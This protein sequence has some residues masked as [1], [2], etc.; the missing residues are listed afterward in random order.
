MQGLALIGPT[1]HFWYGSLGTIVK[2]SGNTGAILRL[3]LDQLCFAPVFIGSECKRSCWGKQ[4]RWQGVQ[5]VFAFQQ[6]T[7][8]WPGQRPRQVHGGAG[9]LLRPACLLSPCPCCPAALPLCPLQP[10]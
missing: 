3:A 6:R 8:G 7:G 9:G 1:L 2:A 4:P 10:S 5:A